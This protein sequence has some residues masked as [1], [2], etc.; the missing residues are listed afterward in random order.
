MTFVETSA[1]EDSNVEE[2]FTMMSKEIKERILKTQQIGG[3]GKSINISKD[4]R[5]VV[6]ASSW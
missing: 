3:L 5:P 2:A 4:R 1:K 6:E